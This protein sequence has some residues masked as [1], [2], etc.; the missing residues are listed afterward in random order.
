MAKKKQSG[1][2]GPREGSGRPIENVEGKTVTIAAS[3]P[4]GLVDSLKDRAAREGWGLSK[5]VTEAIR[6]FVARKRR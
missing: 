1:R 4:G 3:V 5:A 2:G 6:A